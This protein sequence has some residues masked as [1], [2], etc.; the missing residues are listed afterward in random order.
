MNRNAAGGGLRGLQF[1]P[2]PVSSMFIGD[3]RDLRV[4]LT[5]QDDQD[6][7]DMLGTD[8][9]H[10]NSLLVCHAGAMHII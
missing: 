4:G 8:V 9:D 7:E 2:M 5:R 6:L 3:S 1:A 10:Y